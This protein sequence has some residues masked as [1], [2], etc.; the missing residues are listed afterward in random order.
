[1]RRALETIPKDGVIAAR[2]ELLADPE[3]SDH[4]DIQEFLNQMLTHGAL[5]PESKARIT[6]RMS[7]LVFAD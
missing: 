4:E 7:S 6:E 5:T 3:R 1:M 2:L